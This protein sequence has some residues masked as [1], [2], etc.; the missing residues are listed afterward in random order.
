M[1]YSPQ[2]AWKV[3]YT[4]WIFNWHEI[5]KNLPMVAAVTAIDTH[6]GTKLLGLRVSA[7]DDIYEHDASL[8][9]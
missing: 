7:Y 1:T 6:T 5:Y 4:G 8:D 9:D 3:Y 2:I